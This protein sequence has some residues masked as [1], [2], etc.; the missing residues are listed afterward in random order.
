M[1]IIIGHHNKFILLPEIDNN[2]R[3]KNCKFCRKIFSFEYNIGL[4]HSSQDFHKII[5][6]VIKSNYIT[7]ITLWNLTCSMSVC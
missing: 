4:C 1:G 5:C 2:G 7:D 3:F 6:M